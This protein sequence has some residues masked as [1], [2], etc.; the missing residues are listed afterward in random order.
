M[1][2]EGWRLRIGFDAREALTLH[3]VSLG[4]RPVLYRACICEMVVPYADPSPWRF[5]QNYFDAGEYL[6]GQQVNS[7]TLGCDC[8]GEIHYLDAVLSTEG[9]EPRVVD[10]AICM[11][12]EDFGVLW[13][14][15]DVFTGAPGR[16]ASAGW[17]SRPS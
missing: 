4:G 16:A 12:E 15:T 3:E 14:H 6:L 1:E 10:N 7:L 13:K 8:L 9:G 5:W 11:H 2:W 17:S